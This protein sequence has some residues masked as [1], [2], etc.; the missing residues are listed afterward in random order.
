[1]NRGKA[2]RVFE[3]ERLE[4]LTFIH[5]IVPVLIFGPV[6]IFMV[7]RALVRDVP[8]GLVLPLMLLGIVAWSFVEY[9]IHRLAFHFEG[10]TPW[11]RRLHFLVHGIHHD[12]PNDAMR[13]VMPPIVSIPLGIASYLLCHS[14]WAFAGDVFFAGFVTGY[15]GYDYSHFY[16][17]HGRPTS[18]WWRFLRRHHL[19]H[20]HADDRS[21]FGVSSPLW[22]VAFQTLRTE[23]PETKVQRHAAS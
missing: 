4:K 12:D 17:H 3:S 21:N 19:I 8:W 20:H 6:V 18:T 14:L 13:L 16:L 10:K 22:D 23:R 9:I 15:L 11:Q 1:M 7:G 2:I 5:P